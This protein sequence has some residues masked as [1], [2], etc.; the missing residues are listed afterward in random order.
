MK[1]VDEFFENFLRQTLTRLTKT[2]V[3]SIAEEALQKFI[4]A[5]P[6]EEIAN[7]WSY[8]IH[9]YSQFTSLIFTN[10]VIQNGTNMAIVI[11]SGHMTKNGHWV[12]GTHYLDEA[13]KKAY[14]IIIQET[15]EA[16]K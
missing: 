3:R 4:D 1:K 16:L 7:S 13:T 12:E 10:S 5:S 6:N 9:R 2:R 14:D 15:W 8:E 11:N